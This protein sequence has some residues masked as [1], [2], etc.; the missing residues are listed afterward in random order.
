MALRV[1][2]VIVAGI[3]L[4]GLMFQSLSLQA[5]TTSTMTNST[6]FD[7]SRS[8]LSDIVGTGGGQF[9]MLVVVAFVAGVLGTALVVK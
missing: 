3:S 7:A 8:I 9:P 1:S 6:A 5:E 2:V 4:F